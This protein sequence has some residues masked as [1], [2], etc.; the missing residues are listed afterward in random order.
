MRGAFATSDLGFTMV[1][2]Y[3][4]NASLVRQ[5]FVV[6]SGDTPSGFAFV[7]SD[8]LSTAIS[9]SGSSYI[10]RLNAQGVQLPTGLVE[11]PLTGDT[12]YPFMRT[13]APLANRN[14]YIQLTTSGFS[15]LPWNYDAATATPVL[16]K[17]VSAADLVA[18]VAPGGLAAVLGSG[19]SPVTMAAADASLPTILADSCLTLN[20]VAIPLQF[21]SPTRINTQLPF[22]SGGMAEL[23]LH[24]PGGV[25]DSLYVN[26]VPNAP[27]IFR[28]GAA[29][30]ASNIA[31]VYRSSNGALVTPS[32]PVH[33]ED[34]LTIYLTGMGKTWPEVDDGAQAPSSPLSAAL[35]T[36]AVSLG[37]VAL[38]VEYAGLTPGTV[39]VYQINVIVPF[40]GLP[41]G[42]DIPL[43]VSQGGNSTTIPVR[44]V[45]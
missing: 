5:G 6:D 38:P 29:G 13:L 19:L 37:G 42:F 32:N 18:P 30:P 10:R 39:G 22:G 40:K 26:I 9:A 43:T 31:T 15:V 2:H 1:D 23:V 12:D 8:G 16:Q 44:V 17:V 34:R 25:S 28:S 35:V 21:V 7:D 45:N 27:S 36:P 24:T 14:A 20:G 11:A 41:T 3:L 33:M 4:L